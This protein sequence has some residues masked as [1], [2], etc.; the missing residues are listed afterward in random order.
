MPYAR[1]S[2]W[3]AKPASQAPERGCNDCGGMQRGGEVAGNFRDT[4]H[5]AFLTDGNFTRAKA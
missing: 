2:T 3:L 4:T 5:P 1:T